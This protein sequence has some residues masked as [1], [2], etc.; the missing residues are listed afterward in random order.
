MAMDFRELGLSDNEAKAYEALVKFGKITAV[1][2][3]RESGVPYS[4]VYTVLSKLVR[5]GLARVVPGK[6]KQFVATDPENLLKL[7][8]DK[9]VS[10]GKLEGRVKELKEFYAVKEKEPVTMVTGKGAFY[11]AAKEL[12]EPKRSVYRIKYMSEAKP[13]WMRDSR[14]WKKMGIEWKELVRSDKETE[15]DIR[16]WLRIN[17]DIRK[18]P[19]EGVAMRINDDDM[20]FLSLIKSNV[21]LLIRDRPFAKLMKRMFMETYRHAERIK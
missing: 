19:N 5:K 15:R 12:P 4:K 6:T 8:E 3:S 9:R 2:I 16:K 11:K 17:K 21:T 18:L 14:K 20:V 1:K 7:L 13:E 10:L